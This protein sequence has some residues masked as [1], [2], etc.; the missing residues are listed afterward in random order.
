MNNLTRG[1]NEWKE[2]ND[3]FEEYKEHWI[4]AL[5]DLNDQM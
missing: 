3:R 1:T 5:N 2:A 4:D